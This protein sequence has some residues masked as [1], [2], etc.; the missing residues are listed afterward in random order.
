MKSSSHLPQLSSGQ[1]DFS[2]V[3]DAQLMK[4]KPSIS[5]G[6]ISGNSCITEV[7]IN[8]EPT[9]ILLDLG[10]F[11]SCVGNPF[12]KTCVP[13][14]EDQLFPID[15]I[16]FNSESNPMKSLGIYQT[17]VIF[18]KINGD[19]AIPV[20]LFVMENCSST[21]F[22][23][24]NDYLIIYGIDLHNHKARYFT[25][26][27]NKHQKSTFLSFRRQITVKK[28]SPLNLE[29][30]KFKTDQLNETK[31]SLHHTDKQE[32]GLSALLYDHKE[33]FASEKELLGAKIGHE[34]E[35]IINI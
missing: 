6:Y 21:H 33:A 4:T 12:L 3:Q 8:N 23:L 28:V 10:A 5:K 32:N 31:I 20:E 18:P 1:L 17:I 15:C 35:I 7:V 9:K 34:V 22:I 16:K 26:G 30:E 25:I 2:K 19:I 24:G 11:F 14:F 29:L 27:D 13:N